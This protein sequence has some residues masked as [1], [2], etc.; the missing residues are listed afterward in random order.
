LE[1]AHGRANGGNRAHDLV[2]QNQRQLGVWKLAISQVQIGP[3][4][5]AGVD[6]NQHL[7]ICWCRERQLSWADRLAGSIQYNRIHQIGKRPFHSSVARH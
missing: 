2:S 4:D 3:A 6:P 1:S 5:P 7:I